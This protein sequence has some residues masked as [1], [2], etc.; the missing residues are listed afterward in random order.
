MRIQNGIE[1]FLSFLC[2][3]RSGTER[4]R[5]TREK[6]NRK[7]EFKKKNLPSHQLS[8]RLPRQSDFTR[9][10]QLQRDLLSSRDQL[11]D[12]L[13]VEHQFR[14]LSERVRDRELDHVVRRMPQRQRDGVVGD[15]G[16]SRC[17]VEERELVDLPVL[18]RQGL[19]EAVFGED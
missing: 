10:R 9:R 17:S 8:N 14:G 6:T 3:V 5:R 15:G 18:C 7:R 13:L 16:A 4:M 2:C 11:Q 12:Q 1:S 19:V